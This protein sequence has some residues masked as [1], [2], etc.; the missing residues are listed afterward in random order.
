M[1]AQSFTLVCDLQGTAW[2]KPIIFHYDEYPAGWCSSAPNPTCG[3]YV[4]EIITD[5]QTVNLTLNQNEI[6]SKGTAFWTCAHGTKSAGFNA[7]VIGKQMFKLRSLYS[8]LGPMFVML[9]S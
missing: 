6:L 8:M 7:T 2:T 5:N 3:S 9:M 4:G 1:T